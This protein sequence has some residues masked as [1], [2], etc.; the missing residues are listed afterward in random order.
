MPFLYHCRTLSSKNKVY[1]PPKN[2]EN[3]PV[4]KILIPRPRISNDVAAIIYP[5]HAI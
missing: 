1:E 2:G 3:I 4:A 5:Y